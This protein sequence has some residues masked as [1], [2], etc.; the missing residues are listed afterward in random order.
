MV[1]K[2]EEAKAEV[3]EPEEKVSEPEISPTEELAQLRSQLKEI[4][5]NWKNEQRVSS[6]KETDLQQMRERNDQLTSDKEIT[7]ALIATL[8]TQQGRSEEEVS[9]DIRT[10]KPNLLAQYQTILQGQEAQRKVKSYQSRVEA[11]NLTSNDEEYLDIKDLVETGKY[12]RAELKLR[13]LEK[14]KESGKETEPEGNKETEEERID[15]LAEEKSRRTLEERGLL[16]TET[17]GPSA[18]SHAFKEVEK[19]YAEG[20][21][22]YAEYAEARKREHID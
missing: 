10:N 18:A 1:V 6:K 17:G 7:Q 12:D 22:T 15:R 4:E 8:A 2:K 11:L 9:E 5:E 19:A 20:K 16:T 21:I 14:A 13:K 3:K